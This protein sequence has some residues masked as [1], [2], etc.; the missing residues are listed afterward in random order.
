MDPRTQQGGPGEQGA[1][2]PSCFQKVLRLTSWDGPGDRT[3]RLVNAQEAAGATSQQSKA[4]VTNENW[5]DV[6]PSG[7]EGVNLAD[8]HQSQSPLAAENWPRLLPAY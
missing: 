1:P 6:P 5:P 3:G 7:G 4:T 2:T 8:S